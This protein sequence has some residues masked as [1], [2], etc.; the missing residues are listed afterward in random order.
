MTPKGKTPSLLSMSTGKPTIYVCKKKTKCTRCKEEVTMGD[1]CFRIPKSTSGFT[2]KKIFCVDCT[3]SII[4]Q[5]K[6]DISQ[7]ESEISTI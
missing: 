7:I 2:S 6:I 1:K 5:T 4:G 3:D